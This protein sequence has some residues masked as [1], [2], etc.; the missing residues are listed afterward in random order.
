MNLDRPNPFLGSESYLVLLQECVIVEQ[1]LL[2][3]LVF[4]SVRFLH[5]LD[6]ENNTSATV[7]FHVFSFQGNNLF[8]FDIFFGIGFSQTFRIRLPYSS[9]HFGGQ[10]Y[11]IHI[12]PSGCAGP[13]LLEQ[14]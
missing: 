11:C 3:M 5:E 7:K 1:T 9:G 2:L 8:L 12:T 6:L 13:A 14:M 4:D 10:C